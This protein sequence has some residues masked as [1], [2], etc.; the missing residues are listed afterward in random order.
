MII[1]KPMAMNIADAEE[2]IKRAAEKKRGLACHQQN[3]FNVA[4]Q[5]VRKAIE[6]ERFGKLSHAS[7]N[8]RWSGIRD[9]NDQAPWRGIGEEDGVTM[10][11]CASTN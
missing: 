7:I 2:I 3:R 8:V 5:E 6:G 9:I 11:Q 10:N 1:E 4:I